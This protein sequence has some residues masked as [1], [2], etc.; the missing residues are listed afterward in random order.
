MEG[1]GQLPAKGCCGRFIAYVRQHMRQDGDNEGDIHRKSVWVAAMACSF[2]ASS[3][4]TVN[5]RNA[6][7]I[8][9]IFLLLFVWAWARRAVSDMYLGIA[10]VLVSAS[11]FY[12]DVIGVGRGLLV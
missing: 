6:A 1:E 7:A 5:N 12:Y 2:L 10:T 4:A 3:A 8:T 9:V 11:V